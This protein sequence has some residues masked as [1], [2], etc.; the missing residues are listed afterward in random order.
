[1]NLYVIL[2]LHHQQQQQLEIKIEIKMELYE[3]IKI[4][5]KIEV[6]KDYME[7][8]IETE[9][10]KEQYLREKYWEEGFIGTRGAEDFANN[11]LRVFS[12]MENYCCERGHAMSECF[13]G[14]QYAPNVEDHGFGLETTV[15]LWRYLYAKECLGME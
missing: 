9:E 13:D 12:E 8:N 6:E 5:F 10:D 15:N 7:A 1:M 14:D 4:N 11:S 2:I 3:A